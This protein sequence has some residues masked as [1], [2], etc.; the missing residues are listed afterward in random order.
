[1]Y[2]LK[3]HHEDSLQ[4]VMLTKRHENTSSHPMRKSIGIAA[5]VAGLTVGGFAVSQGV[6]NAI[7]RVETQTIESYLQLPANK[8]NADLLTSKMYQ[9]G[10]GEQF[11]ESL[12]NA[13]MQMPKN[14]YKEHFNKIALS[15]AN[16]LYHKTD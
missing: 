6:S 11:E 14:V 1:M 13:Q 12:L 4:R 9:V 15:E 7:Q 3:L 2:N 10:L 16:R 8:I 5:L